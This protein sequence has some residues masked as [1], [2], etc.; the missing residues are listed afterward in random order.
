MSVLPPNTQ[1]ERHASEREL[2]RRIRQMERGIVQ[3][4]CR[5]CMSGDVPVGRPVL[6]CDACLRAK[7]AVDRKGQI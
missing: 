2:K 5:S 3:R 7:W 6:I 1:W 4:R